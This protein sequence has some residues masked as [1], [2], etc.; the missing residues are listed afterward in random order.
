VLETS[1]LLLQG[2]LAPVAGVLVCARSMRVRIGIL[3]NA[4][5]TY[6]RTHVLGCASAL[7]AARH[8]GM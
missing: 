4:K 8:R 6:K 5:T 7:L 2:V 3:L 1:C